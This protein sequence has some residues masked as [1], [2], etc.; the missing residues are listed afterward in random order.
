MEKNNAME[1]FVPPFLELNTE[2]FGGFIS[3]DF[4]LSFGT[5]INAEL[6][7]GKLSANCQGNGICKML[8]VG[9]YNMKCSAVRCTLVKRED[10]HVEMLLYTQQCCANLRNRLLAQEEFI[11]E[12]PFELPSW[13]RTAL[14]MT[15]TKQIPAGSYPMLKLNEC[16]FVSLLL[17]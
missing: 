17:Q 2:V 1:S 8:P 10:N 7:I 5:V 13:I 15:E 4:P 3:H 12:E 11:M 14:R 9:T 6:I 16:A